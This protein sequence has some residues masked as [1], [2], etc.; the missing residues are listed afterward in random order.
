M[1]ILGGMPYKERFTVLEEKPSGKRLVFDKV[2]DKYG[3]Q[4]FDEIDYYEKEVAEQIF[5]KLS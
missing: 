5:K 4:N 3:I 2:M 1:Y